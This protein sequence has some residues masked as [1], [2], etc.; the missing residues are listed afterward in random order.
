ML[1]WKCWEYQAHGCVL[2]S[3]KNDLRLERAHNQLGL[4]SEHA[5]TV[6]CTL[7]KV[8]TSRVWLTQSPASAMFV[9]LFQNSTTF[10]SNRNHRQ[11]L[12]EQTFRNV[13]M[14]GIHK[15]V[16]VF[17]VFSGIK[18]NLKNISLYLHLSYHLMWRQ[19][20]AQEKA[21]QFWEMGIQQTVDEKRIVKCLPFPTIIHIL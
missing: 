6:Y 8:K 19:K 3:L 20:E 18:N 1:V 11:R 5:G 21:K 10:G 15:E 16:C 17:G 12:S 14:T 13:R 2:W 4:W 9:L 7:Y